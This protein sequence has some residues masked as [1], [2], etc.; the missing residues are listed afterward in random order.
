MRKS[1]TCSP[2][3]YSGVPKTFVMR[4]STTPP[5]SRMVIVPEA[6]PLIARATETVVSVQISSPFATAAECTTAPS[7]ISGDLA[8]SCSSVGKTI[9]VA[10]ATDAQ[11]I[12]KIHVNQY[13]FECSDMKPPG[14]VGMGVRLDWRAEHWSE[15]YFRNG[16]GGGKHS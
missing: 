3:V 9:V 11:R 7:T 15:S 13:T 5:I 14:S 6:L 10:P 12:V 8:M 2:S 4:L 1:S 16:G